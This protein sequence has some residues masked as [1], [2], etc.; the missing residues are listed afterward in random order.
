MKKI[1]LLDKLTPSQLKDWDLKCQLSSDLDPNRYKNSKDIYALDYILA[2]TQYF[3][4]EYE[5]NKKEDVGINVINN[6]DLE[7]R[8]M[9]QAIAEIIRL[10]NAENPQIRNN[11]L[12][13]ILPDLSSESLRNLLVMFNMTMSFGN[14]E[15]IV[16]KYKYISDFL[17]IGEKDDFFSL[18]LI[19]KSIEILENRNEYKILNNIS[20]MGFLDVINN[21]PYYEGLDVLY[22]FILEPDVVSLLDTKKQDLNQWYKDINDI[23]LE[24][25]SYD[26]VNIEDALM[27]APSVAML[28]NGIFSENI[29]SIE[30]Y[31]KN[32]DLYIDKLYNFLE[33]NKTSAPMINDLVRTITRYEEK[34]MEEYSNNDLWQEKI[35]VKTQNANKV[36]YISYII[37]V[38]DIVKNQKE[39]MKENGIKTPTGFINFKITSLIHFLNNSHLINSSLKLLKKNNI[40]ICTGTQK[41]I[42]N[43]TLDL[44]TQC[45]NLTDKLFKHQN[46]E[47]FL[48]NE[49][50]QEKVLESIILESCVSTSKKNRLNKF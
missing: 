2:T 17:D 13:K 47:D 40:I 28:K 36:D 3:F 27:F 9:P 24:D 26:L 37:P 21:S 49:K 31:M 12:N 19:L 46:I 50:E 11:A 48:N 8:E 22:S 44:E 41:F 35:K 15:E 6:N 7:I 5:L 18:G 32:K 16:K 10:N 43:S 34:F 20:T 45:K 1:N 42:E 25:D 39:M 29:K 14:E 33:V 23:I 38:E 4:Y 30:R